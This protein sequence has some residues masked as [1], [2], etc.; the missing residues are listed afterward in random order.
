MQRRR[1]LYTV[2]NSLNTLL[3]LFV[4]SLIVP[5]TKGGIRTCRV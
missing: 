2:Y 5:T 1:I 3:V 4:N